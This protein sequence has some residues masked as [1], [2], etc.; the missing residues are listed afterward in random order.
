M[1]AVEPEA[2]AAAVQSQA[3]EHLL[4]C[5]NSPDISA[6]HMT[7]VTYKKD[8]RL[9]AGTEGGR[10]SSQNDDT[11]GDSRPKPARLQAQ[12]PAASPSG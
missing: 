11:I 5:A 7:N 2:A 10:G 9:T 8:R 3:A 6:V 12:R 1:L 4:H